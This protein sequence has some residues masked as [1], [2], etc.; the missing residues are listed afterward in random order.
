MY[1][2]AATAEAVSPFAAGRHD[3]QTIVLILALRRST[4]WTGDGLGSKFVVLM[5]LILLHPHHAHMLRELRSYPDSG[6]RQGIGKDG[7]C[8]TREKGVLL[9]TDANDWQQS[10]DWPHALVLG[11]NSALPPRSWVMLRRLGR[12]W[13]FAKVVRSQFGQTMGAARGPPNGML[14]QPLKPP[15][16]RSIRNDLFDARRANRANR[17]LG[18]HVL[19]RRRLGTLQ[20][21]PIDLRQSIFGRQD[22][23]QQAISA[24]EVDSNPSFEAGFRFLIGVS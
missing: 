10:W 3:T 23:L 18:T 19:A 22:L 21:S 4:A 7:I 16:S 9:F 6:K 8:Q 24:P 14:L 12:T 11:G 20:V 5:A 2:G 15:C 1:P 13:N 17:E